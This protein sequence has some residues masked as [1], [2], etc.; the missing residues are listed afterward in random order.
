MP[1]TP[2][3]RVPERAD[4]I[5]ARDLGDEIVVLD[6]KTQQAHRLTGLDATA[7][8]CA[9][10]SSDDPSVVAHAARLQEI[11]VLEAEGL[12][13]RT[14]LARAGLVAASAPLVSIALPM[15]RAAASVDSITSLVVLSCSNHTITQVRVGV[16]GSKSQTYTLVLNS[17]PSS[18]VTGQLS[19]TGK[20]D[21]NSGQDNLTLSTGSMSVI[22]GGSYTVSWT[23]VDSTDNTTR[24]GTT[25]ITFC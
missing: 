12:S 14:L 21:G 2:H 7:W 11:G 16:T 6:P 10:T 17:P 23:I 13:R 15:A 20:T 25:P 4:G 22:T 3:A 19:G 1:L 24:T 5:V 18:D 9:G 8:R